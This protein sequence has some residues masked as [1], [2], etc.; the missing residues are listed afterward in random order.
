MTPESKRALIAQNFRWMKVAVA[1]YNV[2]TGMRLSREDC[3]DVVM[4]ACVKA[5][6]AAE[7]FDPS[8][9]SMATWLGR[10]A[11]NTASSFRRSKIDTER[12]TLRYERIG[13]DGDTVSLVEADMLYG[14]ELAPN[15]SLLSMEEEAEASSRQERLQ[16]ARMSLSERDQR[17]LEMYEDDIPGA[18]MAKI[19]GIEETAARVALCRAKRHLM[20]A[21]ANM[22][23][24]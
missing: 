13:V 5:Y 3:E 8:K 14:E 22:R 7:S 18:D 1:C 24:I 16:H 15:R 17:L 9:A 19:L 21:Y 20:E 4:D 11:Q 23:E 6:A 10:I 12:C 2:S